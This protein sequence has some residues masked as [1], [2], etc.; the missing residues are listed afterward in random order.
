MRR[1]TSFYGNSR[2]YYADIGCVSNSSDH[3]FNIKDSYVDGIY[4]GSYEVYV[5][6]GVA[7]SGSNFGYEATHVVPVNFN[8][9]VL[10][11]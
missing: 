10:N 9:F 1:G 11:L 4:Y 7:F 8:I 5:D 2:T 3:T 6:D